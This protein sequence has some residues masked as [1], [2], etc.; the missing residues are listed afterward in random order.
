MYLSKHFMHIIKTIQSI[1]II[2]ICGQFFFAE[3]NSGRFNSL[4]LRVNVEN[5][6]INLKLNQKLL[7]SFIYL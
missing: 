5:P 2:K 1:F 4:F 6:D 7:V 3:F